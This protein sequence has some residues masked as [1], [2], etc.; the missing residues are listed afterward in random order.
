MEEHNADENDQNSQ[1]ALSGRSSAWM[2]R[3]SNDYITSRALIQ[4]KEKRIRMKMHTQGSDYG[5]YDDD[6]TSHVS[7]DISHRFSSSG[8]KDDDDDDNDDFSGQMRL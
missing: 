6:L 8:G 2:S 4:R 1:N 5:V 7:S 3:N